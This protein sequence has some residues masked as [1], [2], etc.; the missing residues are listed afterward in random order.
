MNAKHE[1][2]LLLA[3]PLD[4]ANASYDDLVEENR[5]LRLVCLELLGIRDP[6]EATAADSPWF[7]FTMEPAAEIGR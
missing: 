4:I 7:S 1:A 5:R 2:R 3:K 6:R